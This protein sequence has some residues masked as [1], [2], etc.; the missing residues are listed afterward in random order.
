[1]CRPW[2]QSASRM[3][4]PTTFTA[5]HKLFQV[6]LIAVATFSC[7][8]AVLPILTRVIGQICVFIRISNIWLVSFAKME[9]WPIIAISSIV[10]FYVA[11]GCEVN[12]QCYKPVDCEDPD[13]T[14][15]K[16]LKR[17]WKSNCLSRNNSLGGNRM[18]KSII[19]VSISLFAASLTNELL[20]IMYP[21][22]ILFPGAWFSK[23][24]MVIP[25][26]DLSHVS[27]LTCW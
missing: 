11:H 16:H 15:S 12:G 22:W 7:F 26:A 4:S 6:V 1:M 25:P 2:T 24:F 17:H 19:W 5:Y 27:I 3:V 8:L 20:S 14:D 9:L 10:A 13:V 23:K 18:S 21:S